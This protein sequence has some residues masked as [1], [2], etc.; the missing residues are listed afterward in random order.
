MPSADKKAPSPLLPRRPGLERCAGCGKAQTR[1][2]TVCGQLVEVDSPC[3]CRHW[4]RKRGVC[5][6]CDL[7]VTG[8]R[9][10]AVWCDQHRKQSLVQAQRRHLKKV[11]DKHQ[12]AY[13]E[14]HRE[15]L[16]EKVKAAY[17]SD[18]ERRQRRNEYKRQWRKENRG[19]VA[20]QKERA[21]LRNFRDPSR[22]SRGYHAKVAAGSH[23]P[24]RAR[25][26]D[27]GRRLCLTPD[28]PAVVSGRA[29]L[30]TPCREDGGAPTPARH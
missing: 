11:G 4:R 10:V 26:D 14:R 13:R 27:F 29:K 9:G 22:Y 30:C 7:P 12:R 17:R 20:M 28:C 24:D 18:P 23:A 2:D 15:R 16:C 6:A 25:R 3:R 1:M 19:K 8:R 21:A 5:R